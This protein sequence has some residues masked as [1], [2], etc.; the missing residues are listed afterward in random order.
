MNKIRVSRFLPDQ[1]LP[2]YVSDF[3]YIAVLYLYDNISEWSNTCTL[4]YYYVIPRYTDITNKMSL[5]GTMHAINYHLGMLY[6]E[7][8]LINSNALTFN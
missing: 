6:T 2:M 5:Y 3:V 8:F 1:M 7:V 4:L